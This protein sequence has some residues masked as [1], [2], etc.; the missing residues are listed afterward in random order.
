MATGPHQVD[1]RH[2]PHHVVVVGAGVAG[3]GTALTMARAGHRVTLIERD[4]TPLPESPAAAFYW[5]RRGAPQV[6]HSH[7]LLARLRNLL[8]D[9][10]PDVLASL[11]E[12]GATEIRFCDNPPPE[13]TDREPRA[14]DEDLVALACRRTTFEWTLRTIVV[15]LHDVTLLHGTA[16]DALTAVRQ[17][18]RLR[19]TGVVTAD[20]QT[21]EADMVVAA[22]GRRSAVPR[23]LDAH[24]VELASEEEDTGI[25]YLSRFYELHADADL[26]ETNGPIGGDLGYL[27]YGVFL[28]DNRTYSVTLAVQNDDDE[29]RRMLLDPDTF[30][31]AARTLPAT[32]VWAEAGR[33]DAITPV[34]VMGGLLNR[35]VRYVDEEGEPLVLGLHAVGDAH[36]CTNPLYG[37]GCS[38]AMVQADLLAIATREHGDDAVARARAYEAACA[39]EVLPW[40]RASVHQDRLNRERAAR[41]A[42]GE[43]APTDDPA[44]FA[45]QVMRDGLM[46]AVRTDPEVF[47]AFIRTFNLLTTPDAMLTDG[48]VFGRVLAAF[49]DRDNRPPEPVLGPPRT[50]MLE[51]LLV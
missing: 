31:R 27:K 37:R 2:V 26:P 32:A 40:Y 48:E 41:E 17:D 20:G 45:Q 16:I 23:W 43:E 10:Y 8:R 21:V 35:R 33:A 15:G 3:L 46:P 7:A 51:A 13:M 25:V 19:V 38:L 1:G 14:G 50:E 5:D 22:L 29:L 24:G 34:E 36:T 47:R 44:E 9:G 30:D 18:E 42:S 39:R 12:A 6:R 28:G 49:Q 11:L 4:P